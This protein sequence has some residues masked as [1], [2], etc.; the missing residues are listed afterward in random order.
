MGV[1]FIRFA[2]GAAAAEFRAMHW[3][4]GTQ[5]LTASHG[6]FVVPRSGTMLVGSEAT[7]AD[8]LINR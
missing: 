8:Q 3:K 6:T 4:K 5:K 7:R 2:A 1:S